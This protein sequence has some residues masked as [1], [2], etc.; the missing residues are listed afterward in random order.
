MGKTKEWMLRCGRGQLPER[1][2]EILHNADENDLKIMLAMMMAVGEDGK[3]P[4]LQEVGAKY[5][6][7]CDCNP[8]AQIL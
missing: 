2:G 3:V 6:I 1:L 7:Y 8:A 4:P 5:K